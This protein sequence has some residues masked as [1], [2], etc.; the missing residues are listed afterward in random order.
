MA[1]KTFPLVRGRKMRVTRLDACGRPVYGPGSQVVSDGFISVALTA[2]VAD[3]EAISIVNAAGKTTV[4]DRPEAELQGYASEITLTAVNPDIVTMISGQSPVLNPAGDVVGFRM[5]KDVDASM[6]G[7]ALEVWAGVPGDACEPG[8]VAEPSGYILLPFNKGGILGD[9]TIENAAVNAVVTGANS[10]SGSGWGVGPYKVA[11]TTGT[12]TFLA[13][14]ILSGDHLHVQYTEIA[15]PAVTDGAFPLMDPSHTAL[16]SIAASAA[17][18]VA[19]VVPTP[20]SPAANVEPFL[21]EW[22]DGTWTYRNTAGAITHTYAVAGTYTITGTRGGESVTA[23][24]T[25][26]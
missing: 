5:N 24:V 16:T 11:G 3:G 4:D 17:A 20:A 7:F 23:T 1:T 25:V 19:T 9:F 13:T 10:K 15:S 14:P 21:F 6:F 18:L 2:N 12:P 22:G 8:A 26:A